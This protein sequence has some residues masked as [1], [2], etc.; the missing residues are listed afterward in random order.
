MLAREAEVRQRVHPRAD[1]LLLL[2]LL[3]SEACLPSS[4][5]PARSCNTCEG[6]FCSHCCPHW[7]SAGSV[8]RPERATCLM[9]FHGQHALDIEKCEYGPGRKWLPSKF[10]CLEV[11]PSRRTRF[12][13]EV[14]WIAIQ[15]SERP[16]VHDVNGLDCCV[17]SAVARSPLNQSCDVHM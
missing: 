17:C 5:L 9:W 4:H 3:T 10:S 8:L 12:N 6:Y 15:H 1:L 13:T 2:L 14:P 16:V 11:L 7:P